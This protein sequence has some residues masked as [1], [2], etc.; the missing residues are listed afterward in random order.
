[1]DSESVDDRTST[2]VPTSQAYPALSTASSTSQDLSASSSGAL[3]TRSVELEVDGKLNLDEE[4]D[5]GCDEA[6]L[7]CHVA[8]IEPEMMTS[9]TSRHTL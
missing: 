3:S 9:G 8:V 1:M 2:R 5:I 6:F 4:L 7:C